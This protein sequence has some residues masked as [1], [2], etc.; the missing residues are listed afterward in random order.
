MQRRRWLGIIGIAIS[1]ALL[2]SSRRAEGRLD[3]AARID[4]SEAQG[5]AR[6]LAEQFHSPF[7]ERLLLVVRGIPSPDSAEG[8]A[9][10]RTIGDGLRK[11][12]AVGAVASYAE[13]RDDLFLGT[14]GTFLIIGIRPSATSVESF[15][16]PLRKR[17]AGVQR[18]LR[19]KYPGATL[20]L[21]GET[22]LNFDIRKASADDARL[23]ETRVVPVVLVLLLAAFGSAVSAALPLLMGFLA[24]VV[25]MGVAALIAP[26]WHLS[27]LIQNLATMLG[28]GLGIDYALL[29]VSRF[30]EAFEAS[31]DAAHAAGDASRNGGHTLL[32]SASTVAIGFAALLIVPISDIRSIGAAGFFIAAAS[33]LLT[34][35]ILPG[36][37]ELL[38]ARVDLGRIP[39][40]DRTPRPARWR[41]WTRRVTARPGLALLFAGVPL[42]ILSLYSL[43]LSSGL[44]RDDWL[45]REAESVLALHALQDMHRAAL[46]QS[47]RVVL[48]LPA[49]AKV[50]TDRGFDAVRRLSAALARDP[51]TAR[52]LS[53]PSLTRGASALSFVPD[54]MRK[55]FL[56]A[57]ARATLLEVLPKES[58]SSAQQTGWVRELRGVDV[59]GITGLRGAK[60]RIGGIPALNA[61]YEDTIA[62]RLPLVVAWVIGATLLALM[63]GFRSLLAAIKAIVLNLLSVGASLGLLVIVFQEGRGCALVGL[64]G[65]TGGVFPIVP[66]L[67]FAIVFGLSMDY[68]VFLVSR[69]LE[70][71][72][73]GLGEL[74]AIAEGVARTAGIITSAATIMIAV[75]AAFA[76]GSFLVIK[77]IGF[78]LAVAVLIDATLVRIVIGPALLAIGGRWN[79]WPGRI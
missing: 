46:V 54:E 32:I 44:P 76:L 74:D 23:A 39:F 9:A 71:R 68:E 22:P 26:H 43:R 70:A 4:G 28:L 21:T 7:V 37:L 17:I 36:I 29:M 10:I 11:E 38:G 73:S 78:A 56:R 45:P 33:F 5:V 19:S 34:F 6:D 31:G 20:E 66:I 14:G 35:M 49:D 57:D 8:L 69:V 16:P 61:D 52:V 60:I 59:S 3:T 48:E 51:R 41:A 27:I 42:L 30:R 63:A 24:I 12:S 53:L 15:I 50:D 77:M 62:H 67:T 47:M 55:T 65:A 25:T 79:W 13:W 75:F 2:P 72:R 58:V 1:L 64:D 18:D 40:L